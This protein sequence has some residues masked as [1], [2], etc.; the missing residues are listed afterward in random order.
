[1]GYLF[2]A[3]SVFMGTAKGFCG[4]KTSPY[5]SNTTLSLFISTVRMTFCVVI[6]FFVVLI[7]Q[8][9][10][11]SFNLDI[12]TALICLIS[13]IATSIFVVS[14]LLAIKTGAYMMLDVFLTLGTLVPLILSAV[15]FNENIVWLK[16]IGLALLVF[17]SFIML[18]YNA[19]I[20]GKSSIKGIV[21]LIICSLSNGVTQFAQKWFNETMGERKITGGII[22]DATVFN[23]YTYVFSLVSILFCL[24]FFI[25]KNK[26]LKVEKLSA[27]MGFAS[28]FKKVWYYI[29]IMAFCLFMHTYFATLSTNYLPSSEVFPLQRGASTILSLAM[30]SILFKER[31][32]LKCM[33]GVVLT[34][35]GLVI[36]NVFAP[37]L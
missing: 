36:I 14:W 20:K 1:M 28:V 21:L 31:I 23:F 6:G 37:M 4:K 34:F 5:A 18:S 35:L 13:G 10:S 16:W 24:I 33:I 26:Q 9:N 29:L 7:L 30:S 3:L 17:A 27:E 11:N 15:F 2:L 32:T 12:T 8:G 19:K 22:M 25:L